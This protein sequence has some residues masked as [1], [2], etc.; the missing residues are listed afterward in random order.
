MIKLEVL[1]VFVAVAETG[2]IRDAAERVG[3]TASAVSMTLKQLEEEIGAPLFAGDRKSSLTALGTFLLETARAQVQGYDRA[4]AAVRAFAQN[5]IGKLTIACV[6]SVAAQLIPPLLARFL[7]ERPAVELELFDVDS[8]AVAALVE[9]GQVDIGIAGAPRAAGV[10]SFAPLFRD[11]FR[12]VCRSDG[13]LAALGRPVGWGDLGGETLIRNGASEMIAAPEYRALAGAATLMVRNVTSLVAF[14]SAG[15]GVTLLPALSTVGMPEGVAACPLA[16]GTAERE[17]GIISRR[18]V[19]PSPIMAA[20]LT[21][22][23]T[24][25]PALIAGLGLRPA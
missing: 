23:E 21:H 9:S 22:L 3:R 25:S 7:A 20:F 24:E 16:D 19:P 6:P 1:R 12:V 10:L 2:N 15:L 8:R 5:R 4:L 14:A 11:P 17:V 18:D 13:A